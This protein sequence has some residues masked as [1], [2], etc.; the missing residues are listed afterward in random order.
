M[1][2]RSNELEVASLAVMVS[3]LLVVVTLDIDVPGTTVLRA[4][5]GCVLLGVVPGYLLVSLLGLDDRSPG[6]IVVYSVGLSLPL[7][8]C[9]S[10]TVDVVLSGLAIDRPLTPLSMTLAVAA[11]VLCLQAARSVGSGVLRRPFQPLA[12]FEWATVSVVG[13]SDRLQPRVI[14][15]EFGHDER[16]ARSVVRGLSPRDWLALAAV[17]ALP[18]GAVLVTLPG[19]APGSD[20]VLVALSCVVAVVPLALLRWRGSAVLYPYGVWAVAATVLLQMTLVSGHIWGFDIHYEYAT[21]ATILEDGYW[22][23]TGGDSNASL[24]AITLL[25]AVYSMVTGLEIVWVYKLVYPLL[26]SLLPVCLWYIARAEFRERSV[27]V[28]APFTLVFYYG[29]FKDMPDKQLVAGLFGVL[30]LMVFLDERLSALQRWV[31]GLAFA[32]SVVF[33]HYGVSLL[34]VAFLGFGL[35]ARHVVRLVS[36]VG[37]V[38][39]ITRPALVAFFGGFWVL[40][41]ALTASGENLDSVVSVAGEVFEA[42]PLSDSGRSGVGYAM[43]ETESVYWLASKL[44]YI[45]LVGLVGL[46]ILAALYALATDRDAVRNAEYTLFSVGVFGFLVSSAV[47][48]FGMGFDRTLQI[49]LFVLAPFAITGMRTALAVLGRGAARLPRV[50]PRPRLS[51][52]PAEGVFAVFLALLF[53]F[54]SGTAFAVADQPEPAYSI[55]YNQS[56]GW[57]VYSQDEVDA[58]RWL[59]ERSSNPGTDVAVYNNYDRVK[60]RDGLL[61]GEVVPSDRIES[62]WLGRTSFEGPGYVYVS[63]RPMTKPGSDSAYVSVE[64]T[65]FYRTVLAD[66]EP[67]YENDRASVYYI[68][69]NRTNA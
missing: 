29:F 52:I 9:L 50:G 53:L 67:V 34:F 23:A 38:T 3:V 64:R 13:I 59:A 41:Y 18:L 24:V 48:T 2:T 69:G 54:S 25:A 4:V 36:G 21:A 56:A 26:V 58:T 37:V 10:I 33:A 68:R 60:S 20:G 1:D 12:V 39:R 27:A 30:L 40:W 49:A 8:V 17:T 5:L 47:V 22:N 16:T 32:M 57:P 63:E 61:V 55:N 43:T 19:T 45:A 66:R 7:V 28:L 51:A 46:G 42:F 11:L 35:V 65:S 6:P 31:L 14:G 15:W 62:I 44:L